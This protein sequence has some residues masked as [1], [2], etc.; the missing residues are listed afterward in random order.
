MLNRFRIILAA[1]TAILL[2]SSAGA[3]LTVSVQPDDFRVT[4]FAEGLNF[5]LGM[6]PLEDGSIVVAVSN[7]TGF[8]GSTTGRLIRLVDDD[9]DGVA[10]SQTTLFDGV[11][12]GVLTAV[13]RAGDLFFTTGQGKP[14]SIFRAGATPADE[15]KLVG[16]LDFAYPSGW[17]HGHSALAVRPTPGQAQSYDLFFQVG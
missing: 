7:G 12:G 14:I 3:Q 11:P 2:A 10:D 9:D 6:A 13:R 15:L 5:P 16:R 1:A 17:W 8:F 4:V